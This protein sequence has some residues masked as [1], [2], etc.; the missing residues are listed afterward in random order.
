MGRGG[1]RPG[2]GR[3]PKSLSLHRLQGTYR[4]DRHGELAA[5]VP[6]PAYVSAGSAAVVLQMPASSDADW[7]PDDTELAALSPRS[8]SWLEATLRLYRLNALEGQRLLECLRVLTRIEVLEATEGMAAAG[9]VVQ[10]RKLLV[11]MWAALGL[12]Q[13]RD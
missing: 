8:L 6:H 9:Q 4:K 3:K 2:A 1:A 12:E 11:S 13:V 5:A 7:R 10:H